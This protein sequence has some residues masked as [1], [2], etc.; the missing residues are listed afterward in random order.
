MPLNNSVEIEGNA[1]DWAHSAHSAISAVVEQHMELQPLMPAAR[2]TAAALGCSTNPS[3]QALGR[4]SA[5]NIQNTET[6]GFAENGP[7]IDEQTTRPILPSLSGCRANS[8]SADQDSDT[9]AASISSRHVEDHPLHSY[10]R[11]SG[12]VTAHDVSQNGNTSSDGSTACAGQAGAVESD[13][14]LES[15][16]LIPSYS[17]NGD[18][19]RRTTA[20]SSDA[21][22]AEDRLQ[23]A[24]SLEDGPVPEEDDVKFRIRLS[25]SRIRWG[26]VR[27]PEE[28]YTQFPGLEDGAKLGHLTFGTEEQSV[29]PPIPGYFYA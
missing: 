24:R 13:A 15:Q 23:A 12:S 29:A 6:R 2:R 22:D 8:N 10:R 16:R 25:R 18:H 14:D 5:E 27:M 11:I 9:T 3:E 21:G 4:E 7:M 19:S 26:A 28:F 1:D 17:G 20:R